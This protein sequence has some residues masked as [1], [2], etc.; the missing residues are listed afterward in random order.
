MLLERQSQTQA[1]S[2][3]GLA[4]GTAEAG[5]PGCKKVLIF[6][7]TSGRNAREL[8]GALVH[9]IR[10]DATTSDVGK[11]TKPAF[12]QV[13]FCTNITYSSGAST[14]G[15]CT[16][17]AQAS[18]RHV[19]LVHSGADLT[20][21]AQHSADLVKLTVQ[22]ELA[23]GWKELTSAP[24]DAIHVLPSIEDAVRVARGDGKGETDVLVAGSLH[25][26]GGIMEV[27]GLRHAL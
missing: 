23:S 11:E 16:L 18:N 26:V 10:G 24:D 2:A 8:L 14:G 4:T 1:T 7:C 17:S 5:L 19:D 27:A 22:N 9:A 6:N 20:S 21:H 12:D 25:L 15:A 3:P 13:V